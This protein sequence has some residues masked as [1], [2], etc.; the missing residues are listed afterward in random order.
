MK[1]R[2]ILAAVIAAPF[3]MSSVSQAQEQSEASIEL[4]EACRTAAQATDGGQGME[5]MQTGTSQSMESMQGMMGEMTE[6]Q[7]GL[8]QAMM[9]M[10]GLMMQG[11]MNKDA[12]VAWVCAMIPHHQ[13][14]V[15]MARAG[16]EGADNER[17]KELARKTIEDNE[18]SAKELID[19]VNEH[20]ATESQNEA[21]GASAQ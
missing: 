12:D 16:L 21:E 3:L 1:S 15:A 8:S 10:N 4:Q 9:Q 6:T 5:T 7:Q 11:M 2:L 20:A 19:W 17:S 14:A 18:K 13:G